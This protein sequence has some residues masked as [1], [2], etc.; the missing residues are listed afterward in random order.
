MILEQL[1]RGEGFS[2]TE[3]MM[4]AYLLDNG[5]AVRTCSVAQLADAMGVSTASVV[6]LCHKLGLAGYRE[7]RVAFVAEYEQSRH[8]SAVDANVPFERADTPEQIAWKLGN[9]TASALNSVISS[10]DFQQVGRVVERMRQADVVN[11]YTVGTSIPAVL[12]FK[13]KMV[14]LGRAIN[15]DQDVMV[16]RGFATSATKSSFNLLISMSG[17]TDPIVSYARILRARG[18]YCVAITTDPA[19]RLASLSDEVLLMGTREAES[20][21][22]KIETFSSFDATHFLLDCLYCWL[23]QADYD[24]N[25]AHAQESQRLLLEYT[26][27]SR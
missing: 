18:R 14:R 8:T 26:H 4:A 11:V 21:S 2:K 20:F 1:K 16:Q 22:H 23:F 5:A 6:R 15:V 17:E 7:F 3:R 24:R 13:I 12:D 27:D 10:L 25:A 9:L 19:S